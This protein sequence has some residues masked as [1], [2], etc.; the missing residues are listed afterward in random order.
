MSVV[1]VQICSL[2]GQDK[3]WTL[4]HFRLIVFIATTVKKG[5]TLHI[6]T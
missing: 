1:T 5:I 3:P 6:S 4:S 2:Y